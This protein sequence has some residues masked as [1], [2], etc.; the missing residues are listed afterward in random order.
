MYPICPNIHLNFEV[1]LTPAPVFETTSENLFQLQF[2]LENPY[3][4]EDP[5]KVSNVQVFP[6][7]PAK[8]QQGRQMLLGTA[9]HGAAADDLLRLADGFQLLQDV[10]NGWNKRSCDVFKKNKITIRYYVSKCLLKLHRSLPFGKTNMHVLRGKLCRSGFYREHTGNV[11][12]A[13]R[14]IQCCILK[15]NKTFTVKP[16]TCFSKKYSANK[17][18]MDDCILMVLKRKSDDILP[19]L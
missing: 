2:V 12:V 1:F 18:Y 13:N 6:V 17:A 19:V 3:A 7:V 11:G 14:P 15:T 5:S 10:F 16:T 9:R 4:M 8:T